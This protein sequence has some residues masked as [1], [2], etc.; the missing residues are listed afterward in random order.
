MYRTTTCLFPRIQ[1]DDTGFFRLDDTFLLLPSPDHSPPVSPPFRRSV[2]SLVARPD[3]RIV[4]GPKRG[5]TSSRAGSNAIW[6][7]DST[8]A[9]TRYPL[10]PGGACSLPPP[11]ESAP[12]DASPCSSA[13]SSSANSSKVWVSSTG[14]AREAVGAE[15][16]SAEVCRA[17]LFF[18]LAFRTLDSQ[19]GGAT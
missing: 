16:A 4:P 10:V 15:A 8:R 19:I 6:L 17:C 9:G 2:V 7:P 14:S 12:H 3:P 1:E 13:S 5:D 11:E 18:S